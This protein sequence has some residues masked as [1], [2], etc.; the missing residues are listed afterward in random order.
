MHYLFFG[1]INFHWTNA[2]LTFNY[3]SIKVCYFHTP[4]YNIENVH[5]KLPYEAKGNFW[6]LS[7]SVDA[8]AGMCLCCSHETKPYIL[9]TWLNYIDQPVHDKTIKMKCVLGEDSDQSR[10]RPHASTLSD[11]SLCYEFNQY[12]QT[13]NFFM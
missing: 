10:H 8:Q 12:Q 6:R 9:P 4:G 5:V 1:T 7:D 2:I 11:Q 3:K 13:R